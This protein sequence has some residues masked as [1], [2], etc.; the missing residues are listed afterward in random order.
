MVC[1]VSKAL[2]LLFGLSGCAYDHGFTDDYVAGGYGWHPS[3]PHSEPMFNNKHGSGG[4]VW[5]PSYPSHS[6]GFSI[7]R[8][9]RYGNPFNSRYSYYY[10]RYGAPYPAPGYLFY[11]H[12]YGFRDP[13]DRLKREHRRQ[14]KEL[15]RERKIQKKTAAQERKLQKKT[16]KHE[17]KIQKRLLKQE[18]KLAKKQRKQERKALKRRAQPNLGN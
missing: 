16:L 7:G 10:P 12:P 14:K 15:K 13:D 11:S 9:Y 18:R 5:H 17:R 8:V 4:Y 1:R 6:R 3:A 2:V